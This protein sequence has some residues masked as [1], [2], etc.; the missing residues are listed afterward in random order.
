MLELVRCEGQPT[1]ASGFVGAVGGCVGASMGGSSGV[2]LE[3][4][5]R[6][7]AR[8]LA[9]AP[10]AGQVRATMDHSAPAHCCL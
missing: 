2:L 7:M 6:A 10:T 5:F 3:I 1:D 8:A 4:F 9:N